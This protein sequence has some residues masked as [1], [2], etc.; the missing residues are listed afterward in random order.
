MKKLLF[1]FL[2]IFSSQSFAEWELVAE[3]VNDKYYID[4]D[5]IRENGGYIYYWLLVN[6][7]EAKKIGQFYYKSGKEYVQADCKI[8]RN[9]VLQYFIYPEEFGTGNLIDM[10]DGNGSWFYPPP[11]T[12][13]DSIL[14]RVCE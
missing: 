7:K 1:I 9:K 14:K 4:F 12:V 11:K 6:Q 13:G 8:F 5:N 3:S 2:I 10:V